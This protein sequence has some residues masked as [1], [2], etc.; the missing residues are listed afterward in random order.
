MFNKILVA[1]DG[2]SHANKALELAGNLAKVHEAA[3]VIV[4]VMQ[5]GRVPESIRR[6]V[7]NEH[8][9]EQNRQYGPRLAESARSLVAVMGKSANEMDQSERA[10]QAYGE[11][12]LARSEHDAHALGIRSVQTVMEDGDPVDCILGCAR[13]HGV[14]LIILGTRGLSDL[15]GMLMGS[16]SHKVVQLA[17]CTCIS[18]K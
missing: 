18:V 3:L 10:F 7:E 9:V 16:V 13:K 5:H 4:H 2:S 6:M 15:K 12:L 1:T 14:D 11:H 17:P 8:L